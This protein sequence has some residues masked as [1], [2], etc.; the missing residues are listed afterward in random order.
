MAWRAAVPIF[1]PRAASDLGRAQRDKSHSIEGEVAMATRTVK[2]PREGD[3]GTALMTGEAG[4]TS[5]GAVI[6]Q[7]QGVSTDVMSDQV[8]PARQKVRGKPKHKDHEV[9]WADLVA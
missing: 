3:V 7:I 8:V 5:G 4:L 9:K 6:Y 1:P 2:G